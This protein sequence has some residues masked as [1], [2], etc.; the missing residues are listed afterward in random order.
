MSTYEGRVEAVNG[1]GLRLTDR[2]EWLNV[3]KF[4]PVTL[5]A[6]GAQIRVET[7]AKGFIKQLTVLDQPAQSDRQDVIARLTVLKAAAH[8]A[9]DR[10]DIKSGDVLA[11]ADRWLAWVQA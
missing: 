7:D 3:S 10:V 2:G 4:A 8:F 9:A 1:T 6:Q 11:I 5:P